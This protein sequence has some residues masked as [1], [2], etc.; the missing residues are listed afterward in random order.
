MFTHNFHSQLWQKGQ[1][2][3]NV[4]LEEMCRIYK[5]LLPHFITLSEEAQGHDVSFTL[6]TAPDGVIALVAKEP[7]GHTQIIKQTSDQANITYKFGNI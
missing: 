2:M 7:S 3:S 4:S 6:T 1:K 5:V